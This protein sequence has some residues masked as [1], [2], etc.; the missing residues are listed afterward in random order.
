MAY[1]LFG[2]A[3]INKH[4]LNPPEYASE[5]EEK[6]ANHRWG[7]ADSINRV[8]GYIMAFRESTDNKVEIKQVHVPNLFNK[9]E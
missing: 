3:M 2:M 6:K 7:I 4:I 8:L 1:A 5:E 9:K